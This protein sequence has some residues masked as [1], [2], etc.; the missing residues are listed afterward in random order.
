MLLRD[1]IRRDLKSTFNGIAWHGTPVR[2]LL[3]DVDETRAHA[4]PIANTRS[5]AELLA[6]L[7]AWIEI[8]AR[9]TTGEEFQVTPEMDFPPVEGVRWEDQLARLDAAHARLLE[10]VATLE[11]ADFDRMV[12]GQKYPVDFMLRGL[13]HHTTYHAAQIAL[14]K[15]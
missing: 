1:R 3:E 9:R 12:D 4:H 10:V 11:D 14:L 5:I 8:V 7:T 6:H 13:I 2:K 15:K